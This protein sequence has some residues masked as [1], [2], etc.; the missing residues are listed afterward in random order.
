M[1]RKRFS[2]TPVEISRPQEIFHLNEEFIEYGYNTS[3]LL[4]MYVRL[5]EKEDLEV[6]VR[7]KKRKKE[8]IPQGISSGDRKLIEDVKIISDKMPTD[9]FLTIFFGKDGYDSDIAFENSVAVPEFESMLEDEGKTLILG[10]NPY[11]M[12]ARLLSEYK[13]DD[14]DFVVQDETIKKMYTYQFPTSR[15]CTMAEAEK[16]GPYDYVYISSIGMSLSVPKYIQ[17]MDKALSICGSKGRIMALLPNAVYDGNREECF[18]I[19]ESSGAAIEKITILP[20]G[21]LKGSGIKKQ[22]V[23]YIHRSAEKQEKIDMEVLSFDGENRTSLMQ[24]AIKGIPYSEFFKDTRTLRVQANSMAK[25]GRSDSDLAIEHRNGE[26]TLSFSREIRL[27]YT[28]GKNRG[29]K[30]ARA[31]YRSIKA[32][33]NNKRGNRLSGWIIK[34]LRGNSE[35]EILEKLYQLPLRENISRIIRS[36]INENAEDKKNIYMLLI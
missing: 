27:S 32:Y 18:R 11:S 1:N 30:Y 17:V 3:S 25:N 24:T 8:S 4:E 34:G 16:N 21:L 33:K 19:L 7:S 9:L 12:N 28:I 2:I 5:I 26:Q 14:Y 35:K 23:F 20:E 31:C 29:K 6:G 15:F 13:Y 10:M 22:S 36:D